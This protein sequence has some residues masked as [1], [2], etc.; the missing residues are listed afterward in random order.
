MTISLGGGGGSASVI[1]SPRWEYVDADTIRVVAQATSGTYHVTMTS[2]S[3]IA[4]ASTLSCDLSHTAGTPTV[5]GAGGYETGSTPGSDE[6]WHVYVIDGSSGTA[7]IASSKSDPSLVTLPSGYTSISEPYG[8]HSWYVY[9]NTL[10]EVQKFAHS[11]VGES[12]TLRIA[13]DPTATVL[14]AGT[15]VATT[16]ID[17]SGHVPTGCRSVLAMFQSEN[18]SAVLPANRASLGADMFGSEAAQGAIYANG[19]GISSGSGHVRTRWNRL[20]FATATGSPASD[21]TYLWHGGAPTGGM[22]VYP[23]GWRK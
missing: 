1:L 9:R 14:A 15:A 7:L 3:T 5:T 19:L 13:S 23:H 11:G 21:I 12:T 10:D 17:F 6:G 8:D 18:N 22:Y 2:G 20:W 4:V 16:S